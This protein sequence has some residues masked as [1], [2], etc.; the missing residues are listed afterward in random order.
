MLI[1]NLDVEDVIAQLLVTEG[2]VS[3]EGIASESIEDLTKIEG[4]DEELANELITR[5]TNFMKEKNA[6]DIKIIDEKIKDEKL[7]GLEGMDNKMLSLL[8]QNNILTIDDFADLATFELIDKEEGFFREL[9]IDE[10]IINGMI[11]KAREKWFVKE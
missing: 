10:N 4:F 2:Y 9:E 6:E 8:A 3:I 5:S 1:S 11:M 7:K